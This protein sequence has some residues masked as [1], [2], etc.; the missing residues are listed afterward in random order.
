MF[1]T[2][3]NFGLRDWKELKAWMDHAGKSPAR[4][5]KRRVSYWL[6][7]DAGGTVIGGSQG[8]KRDQDRQGRAS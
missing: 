2:I 4:P 1:L 8:Q 5:L 7:P 3:P 6:E